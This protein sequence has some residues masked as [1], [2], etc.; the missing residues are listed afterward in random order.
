[1]SLISKYSDINRNF[2]VLGA[3]VLKK[4]KKKDCQTERL[5]QECKNE[6]NIEINQFL[7]IITVLWSLDLIQ[8]RD[9][10]LSIKKY[11]IK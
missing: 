11:D 1:M 8:L 5:F 10:I 6:L 3:G 9:N 2:L 4:L 7:N